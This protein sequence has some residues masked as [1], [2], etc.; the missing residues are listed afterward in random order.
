[1]SI[2]GSLTDAINFRYVFTI[3]GTPTTVSGAD[4]NSKTLA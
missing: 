4:D 3:S 2:A 1:M